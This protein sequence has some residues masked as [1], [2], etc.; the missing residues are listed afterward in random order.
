MADLHSELPIHMRC[1]VHFQVISLRKEL[2]DAREI[3]KQKDDELSKTR[4]KMEINET[5]LNQAE[6]A[7][8]QTMKDLN[9]KEEKLKKLQSEDDNRMRHLEE[10][11]A[12]LQVRFEK[13]KIKLLF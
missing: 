8:N 3:I 6:S 5:E 2:S 7:L 4:R 9:M 11:I 13:L 10:M 1:N 12:S